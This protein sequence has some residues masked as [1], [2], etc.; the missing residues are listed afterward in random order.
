MARRAI[1][2]LTDEPLR[3]SMGKESR[4]IAVENYEASTVIPMYEEFYARITGQTIPAR[5]YLS[6][7]EGLA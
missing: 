5:G 2:L 6:P 1:E 4:R 3:C 7:P